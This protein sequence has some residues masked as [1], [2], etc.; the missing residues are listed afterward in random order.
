MRGT[1][2]ST[3]TGYYF[4]RHLIYVF[5]PIINFMRGELTE[6]TFFRWFPEV[7]TDYLSLHTVEFSIP[8]DDVQLLPI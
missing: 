2:K 7:E 6:E 3:G 8:A 5:I 4:F 1:P